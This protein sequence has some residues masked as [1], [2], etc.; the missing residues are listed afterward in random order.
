MR[1]LPTA[2]V[3]WIAALMLVAAPAAAQA[4]VPEAR[5][6]AKELV[7]TMRATDQLK[8]MMPMIMQQLKPMIVQGR[9]EVERDFDLLLPVVT[10]A[11]TGR[12]SELVEAVALVYAAHFSAD[13]LRQITAFYRTAVG[14]KFLQK[15]PLITQQSMAVGQRFGEQVASGLR[16]CMIEELRKKGHTI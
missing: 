15:L 1:A 9:P 16:D 12:M 14:E 2:F 13:E 4:P 6:A 8:A 11:M 3:A 5:A 10:D 7:E